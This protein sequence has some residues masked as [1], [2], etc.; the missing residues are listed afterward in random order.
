MQHR[1]KSLQPRMTFPFHIAVDVAI[2][3][4]DPVALFLAT[5][6]AEAGAT[7]ALLSPDPTHTPLRRHHGVS[8]VGLTESL[9]RTQ[10]S[11]GP[12]YTG[13]LVAHQVASHGL[14]R[15]LD[16]VSPT[17]CR[18][19]EAPE[20][21]RE[22]TKVLEQLGTSWRLSPSGALEV[23]D[24]VV[25]QPD[26]VFGRLIE[27]AHA[28][29]VHFLDMRGG[30][31]AALAAREGPV[32]WEILVMTDG[33]ALRGLSSFWTQ[34][35]T[36]IRQGALQVNTPET[37]G[38]GLTTGRGFTW[39]VDHEG[40]PLVAGCRWATPHLEVGETERVLSPRVRRALTKCAFE[41][42][43]TREV[44]PY[45]C[46]IESHTCD[47]LPFVGA[48][49]GDPTLI[50]CTGWA[51]HLWSLG[52][53]AAKHIVAQLCEAAAPELPPWMHPGRLL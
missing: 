2:W 20:R 43:G 46:W 31:P 40:G 42:F 7:V 12:L 44:S 19:E 8:Q 10:R 52:P 49:P 53:Q 6:L 41:R 26:A 34:C 32:D 1:W 33:C 15:A 51:E 17:P 18:R 9:E 24:D 45:G 11:L 27:R 37:I 39:L 13:Q 30:S 14:L 35:L 47:G 22:E 28:L 38:G 3:G 29:G 4:D 23:S 16:A 50:A 48:L 5:G 25:V 36:P 21:L